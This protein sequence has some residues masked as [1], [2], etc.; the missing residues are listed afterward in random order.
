[1]C[2][3]VFLRVVAGFRASVARHAAALLLPVL[4]L[5]LLLLL[6]SQLLLIV[7]RVYLAPMIGILSL[8]CPQESGN[9]L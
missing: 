7:L 1:M 5:L 9:E 8:Q 6:L 4:L 3:F 2:V